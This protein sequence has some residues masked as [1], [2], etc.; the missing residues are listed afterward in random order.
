MLLFGLADND[1]ITLGD[2]TFNSDS[3]AITHIFEKLEVSDEVEYNEMFRLGKK[4]VVADA[5]A[6]PDERPRCRPI[7]M[8]FGSSGM[9]KL[10]LNNSPKLKDLFGDDVKLYIKPDKTKSERE[11]YNLLGKK[12]EELMA[13]HP[14]PEGAPPRVV[15]KSGR[16]LVDG[17]QVDCYK[18]PQTLF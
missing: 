14:V 8:C 6:D 17:E 11:Q 13:R 4:E 7:K 3:D 2:E 15:L 10:I 9:A 1:V 18:A 16:L 5:E 12:K